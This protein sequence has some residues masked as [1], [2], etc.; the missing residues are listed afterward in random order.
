MDKDLLTTRNF[1]SLIFATC[2]AILVNTAAFAQTPPKGLFEDAVSTKSANTPSS[3]EILRSR[4]IA[5]DVDQLIAQDSSELLLNLFDDVNTYARFK[6]G[7]TNSSGSQTWIGEIP[8]IP[9][10]SIIFVIKDKSVF[11]TIDLPELGRFSIKPNSDTT[12]VVQQINLSIRSPA[13]TDVL[14]PPDSSQQRPA[15]QHGSPIEIS[16]DDGSII[17][18]Y[19]AFDQDAA[20]GAVNASEAEALAELF[21]AYTNQAFKNSNIDQRIWLVGSVDGY[22]HEDTNTSSLSS[23]LQDV[24]DGSIP[25]LHAKRNE[26]HADLVLFFTPQHDANTCSGIAWLQTTNNDLG[27]NEYGFSAMTACS[28]GASTFAHELGHNMGSRH[29]WYVDSGVTPSSTGHGYVDIVKNFQTIMS[30][31]NRC[32]VL[33]KNCAR[34]PYF[35][36]PN[37]SYGGAPTGVAAG[38][39]TNC[40]TG[41]PL[42]AVNCDAD[43][44]ANFD[45]KSLITSKFRDSRITWTGEADSNWL[46]PGNWRMNQGAPGSTSVVRR[47]PRSFDNVLIPAGRSRYPVITSAAMA[48]ELTIENGAT[49]E[50]TAGTLS[51]GWSWEDNGGFIAK[52]G[53]VE[54]S[55][56]IGITL[57]TSSSFRN[58][59][60]GSGADST[61]VELE[62][63]LDINGNLQI[64]SGATLSAGAF[65]INL[66]GNWQ[67]NSV[68]GFKAGTSTVVMDGVNQQLNKVVA[69][70]KVIEDFSKA[71]GTSTSS[72]STI[73]LPDSWTNESGWYGGNR[74][75]SGRAVA[76]GNQGDSWLHSDVLSL[77]SGISYAL[78]LDFNQSFS[79]GD[80]LQ[81]Y[82]GESPDSSAMNKILGSTSTEGS[83]SLEFSV[84]Q[85]SDYFIGFKHI[86]ASSGNWSYMDNI[87]L[88]SGSG[89]SF[90][91]LNINSGVSN[92]VQDT[93]VKNNLF[94]GQASTFVVAESLVSV[95]GN[96]TNNGLFKQR[97][98]VAPNVTTSF[99]KIYNRAGT[100]GKYFGVD[101]TTANSLGSTVVELYGNQTCPNTSD[102]VKRCYKISPAN[103]QSANVKFYYGSIEANGNNI[104]QIFREVPTTN[105]WEVIPAMD[106]GSINGFLW[107]LS[108]PI[109]NFGTF[110][111]ANGLP[112]RPPNVRIPYYRLYNQHDQRHFYTQDVAEYNHLGTLGWKLEGVGYYIYDS[113]V[114][115]NNVTAKPWYRLY[116]LELKVHLWTLSE[117]EYA[118]LGNSGWRQEGVAGYFFASQVPGSTPLYRLYNQSIKKHHWT[119]DANENSV[120]VNLGWKSEGIV[121]YVFTSSE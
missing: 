86:A 31:N 11:G 30:Y 105:P 37:V 13:T 42:P 51:V 84:D 87:S 98:N 106:R 81:V 3:M 89:L 41:D 115:V 77:T 27:F 83:M 68:Q 67:E 57:T 111:L 112:S 118:S 47:V 102:G 65:R 120:L 52:G 56:P 40:T 43:N 60:I 23:D 21:V 63:N 53:T 69:E 34:I 62:S 18:V 35:S 17:D 103:P 70:T 58:L 113:A 91:N 117:V 32:G 50:M 75:G 12:H 95:D 80:V 45:A 79:P 74:D 104:P 78:N 44:K 73:Y 54:L 28:F 114:T 19:V 15:E 8:D 110:S 100:V 36:N 90:H 5:V 82:I 14:I 29:D 9:N 26:Y 76:A 88:R 33:G 59:K 99:G 55:G 7:Y 64:S 20:G 22:N 48:R 107:L 66:A 96:V 108:S 71:D 72:I 101:I 1:I 49:V 6:N 61:Y 119:K 46:N 97:R 10:S 94:I 38:T 85:S 92:F 25:G 4:T 39:N 2:F 121:G 16:S 109:S 93:Y 116:H 24:T